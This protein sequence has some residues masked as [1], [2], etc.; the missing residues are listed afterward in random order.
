MEDGRWYRFGPRQSLLAT[1]RG[2]G[3]DDIGTRM[4][5]FRRP[6]QNSAL[7]LE[8]PSPVC[9]QNCF[10]MENASGEQS[11]AEMLGERDLSWLDTFADASRAKTR[12]CRSFVIASSVARVL[13]NSIHR[14]AIVGVGNSIAFCP[15]R[16]C[17]LA[18]SSASDV[19]EVWMKNLW[20]PVRFWFAKPP[21]TPCNLKLGVC[22]P[23]ISRSQLANHEWIPFFIRYVCFPC[24]QGYT[25]RLSIKRGVRPVGVCDIFLPRLGGCLWNHDTHVRSV[26]RN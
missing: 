17:P 5:Y 14:P 3:G 15:V 26:W 23:R 16:P 18:I 8:T 10:A 13:T 11:T 19:I 22:L 4:S 21:N 7:R 2:D 24:R 12:T 20:N 1:R 25:D 9:C 6:W